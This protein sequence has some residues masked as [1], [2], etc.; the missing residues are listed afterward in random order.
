MWRIV[1]GLVFR[2]ISSVLSDSFK[3]EEFRWI[4]LIILTVPN[5]NSYTVTLLWSPKR[6]NLNNWYLN[7]TDILLT[8][9][10]I[11]LYLRRQNENITDI[12]KTNI[13]FWVVW[14]CG[15]ECLGLNTSLH[16]QSVYEFS[17]AQ[18]SQ[19]PVSLMTS[20]L[21]QTGYCS[22]CLLLAIVAFESPGMYRKSQHRWLV[23]AEAAA[24]QR[25]SFLLQLNCEV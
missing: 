3:V 24:F 25:F 1:P 6:H 19:N 10:Y 20:Y 15:K 11:Y 9:I 4:C 13:G 2:D 8:Y 14:T 21:S 17:L 23:C 22:W 18:N 12:H 7:K 16:G 5:K